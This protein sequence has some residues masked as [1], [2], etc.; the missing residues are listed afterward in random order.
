LAAITRDEF[1]AMF[2]DSPVARTKYL[3]F[4][5]NVAIAMGNQRDE[6]FRA[7]LEQLALSPD[8]VVAEAARWAIEQLP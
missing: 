4:L 5:R 3:G 6:S 8:P 7:P 2:R 1:R